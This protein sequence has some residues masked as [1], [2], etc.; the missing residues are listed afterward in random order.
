[1]RGRVIL[2]VCGVVALLWWAMPAAAMPSYLG[3]SGLILTPDSQTNQFSA[4]SFSAHFFDLRGSLKEHGLDG[5][6]SI[7]AAN[8]SPIPAL[9]LGISSIESKISSRANMLN[10]KFIIKQQNNAEPVAFVAG[11]V[12]VLDEQEISPYALFSKSFRLSGPKATNQISLAVNAGYGGGFYNDGILIGG[13][14]KLAPQ[15]SLL[16]EG[17]KG[18]VNLGARFSTAGL[19][20]DIGFMDMSELG[21]GI[22]YTWSLGK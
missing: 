5:G 22:S 9:E 15:F 14:L 4:I 2:A 20:V 8:Y 10:G 11:V 7:L 19:A 1:M 13:E 17:T 18:Y 3:P 6:T 21:G 12:D 16:A